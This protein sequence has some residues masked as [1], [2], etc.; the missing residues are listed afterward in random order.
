MSARLSDIDF[1]N[2]EEF[3]Q[4]LDNMNKFDFDIFRFDEIT[5]NKSLFYFT[6]EL[7]ANYNFFSLIEEH[8]FKEFISAIKKGYSRSNPYHNDIHAVDVLQSC[9]AIVENG[10]LAKVKII[11]LSNNFLEN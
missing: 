10:K 8:I 9:F 2:L 7:F 1:Q 5:K 4:M 3:T 11:Y 6:Y